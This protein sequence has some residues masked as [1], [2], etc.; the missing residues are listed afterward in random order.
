MH[1]VSYQFIVAVVVLCLYTAMMQE[2]TSKVDGDTLW[3]GVNMTK[4][5]IICVSIL[6]LN[7]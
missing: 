6:I 3:S 5:Q 4:R 1:T 2:L 7:T